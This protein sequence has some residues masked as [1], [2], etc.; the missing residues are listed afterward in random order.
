MTDLEIWQTLVQTAVVGA[1]RAALPPP[2]LDELE[3]RGIDPF[4]APEEVLLS[5]AALVRQRIRAGQLLPR[6]TDIPE[7][8]MPEENAVINPQASRF[9]SII[10][11]G[12]FAPALREWVGHFSRSGQSLPP[13]SLPGLLKHCAG[14]PAIRELLEPH[15]GPRARWLIRQNPDWAALEHPLPDASQQRLNQFVKL[16][17]LD[18][19]KVRGLPEAD[20]LDALKAFADTCLSAEGMQV[21]LR[22]P[23]GFP[24]WLFREGWARKRKAADAT[25][26]TALAWIPPGHWTEKLD[27]APDFICE[28]RLQTPDLALFRR[29]LAHAAVLYGDAE[30][31]AALLNIHAIYPGFLEVDPSCL[32]QLIALVPAGVFQDLIAQVWADAGDDL[33]EFKPAEELLLR[34]LHPWDE[35]FAGE[36]LAELQRVLIGS[37]DSWDLWDHRAVLR[38]AAYRLPVL[39]DAPWLGGWT[40]M[41]QRTYYLWKDDI[42]YFLRV[43]QFRTEMQEAFE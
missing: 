39:P 37:P 5:A 20:T 36:W 40:Q 21:Q 13:E 26:Q 22:L 12:R 41:P 14:D 33:D 25:L 32:A 16:E 17:K 15:L 6:L 1:E 7:P 23:D 27:S 11:S 34:S 31:A 30:W 8:P 38:H 9:L 43:L 29:S 42:E 4:A 3:R 28:Y 24:D 35:E 19:A 18:T 10:L 2:L